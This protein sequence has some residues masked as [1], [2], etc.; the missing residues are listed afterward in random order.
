L[1]GLICLF[2]YGVLLFHDFSDLFPS[3]KMPGVLSVLLCLLMLGLPVAAGLSWWWLVSWWLVVMSAYM[4]RGEAFLACLWFIFLLGSPVFLSRYGVFAATRSDAAL[5]AALRVRS[6]VP[7]GSDLS[8]LESE[9]DKRP[10]DLL[11][12]FSLAQLLQREGRF[13]KAATVYGPLFGDKRTA[14]EAYND[15]AEIYLWNGQLDQ[16]FRALS[17]AVDSGGPRAEVL[18]NLGQYYREAEQLVQMDKEYNAARRIDQKKVE[19]LTDR[20]GE[21]K[22]NRFMASLPAP[23]SLVWERSLAGS[24]MAGAAFPAIWNSWMGWP[25]GLLFL[26]MAIAGPV[27]ILMLRIIGKGWK[28]STRCSSCGRP[29]CLTCQKPP[30]QPGMCTPCYNVF[31]GEGGVDL[32]VKM[33]KRAEVQRY[34]DIWS[35]SGLALAILAPGSGQMLLGWTGAGAAFFC[36]VAAAWSVLITGHLMWPQAGPAYHGGGSGPGILLIFVYLILMIISALN[37]RARID[38]WR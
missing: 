15:V 26:A 32:K 4:K 6:G 34:R 20:G 38:R 33:Q 18:F 23:R 25:S 19:L 3:R 21:W 1:L 8:V 29:I 10:D 2:R 24:A 12:R 7:S 27:L 22:L 30:R 36:W 31:R 35:R 17:A 11:V 5:M 9:L 14:Q 37:Y 13:N 16:V 28:L